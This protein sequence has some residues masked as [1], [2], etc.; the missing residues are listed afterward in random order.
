MNNFELFS[1]I[2]THLLGETTENQPDSSLG[3]IKNKRMIIIIVKDNVKGCA[4]CRLRKAGKGGAH[5]HQLPAK[6]R[7]KILQRIKFSILHGV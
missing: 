7:R 3:Q 1:R 5:Q 2:L 4:L 6:H